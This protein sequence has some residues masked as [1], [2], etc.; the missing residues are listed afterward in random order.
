LLTGSE[1]PDR[2]VR[3]VAFAGQKW[4]MPAWFAKLWLRDLDF[5]LRLGY[6]QG[7]RKVL[8]TPEK[9][10]IEIVNLDRDPFGL[11]PTSP[12]EGAAPFEKEVESLTNWFRATHLEQNG[13]NRRTDKDIEALE[14]LGYIQ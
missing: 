12:D 13:E 7:D 6:R 11:H 5:P 2:I 9:D 8:W 14:S 3:F 1:L 10:S 4:I